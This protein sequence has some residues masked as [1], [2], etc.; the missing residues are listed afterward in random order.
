MCYW[1]CVYTKLGSKIRTS[2]NSSYYIGWEE[3]C[4]PKKIPLG[5]TSKG[6][7]IYSGIHVAS[8]SRQI[9][10]APTRCSLFG[11]FLLFAT[12]HYLNLWGWNP[13][14]S[15]NVLEEANINPKKLNLILSFFWENQRPLTWSRNFFHIGASSMFTTVVNIEWLTTFEHTIQSFSNNLFLMFIFRSATNHPS[16]EY[17]CRKRQP[18]KVGYLPHKHHYIK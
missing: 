7:E 12:I 1:G 13:C 10:V 16:H 14:A 5:S 3:N 9:L 15:A 17:R 11:S 4:R 6:V 2:S 18:T 8:L